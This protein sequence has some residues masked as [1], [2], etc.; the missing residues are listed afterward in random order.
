MAW[1]GKVKKAFLFDMSVLQFFI[2]APCAL[3]RAS[4]FEDGATKESMQNTDR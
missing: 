3:T 1:D 4:D 2:T